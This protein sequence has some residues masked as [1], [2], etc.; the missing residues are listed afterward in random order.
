MFQVAPAHASAYPTQSAS[1]RPSHN[2]S[3][4]SSTALQLPRQL[5]RPALVDVPAANIAACAPELSGVPAEYIRRNL[6]KQSHEMLAGIQALSPAHL[7]K[8]LPKSRLPEML[9]VPIVQRTASLPTHILAVTSS[10]SAPSD[11]AM[12]FAVHGIVIA[13]HCAQMR[14]PQGYQQ[15]GSTARLPVV[16]ISPPSAHAFNILLDFMYTH[17]LDS[18]LRSLLPLPSSFCKDIT[19]EGVKSTTHSRS[20]IYQL[21]THLYNHEHGDVAA[22]MRHVG[23]CKDMWQDMIS[24]GM[25]TPELWDTLDLA[26]TIVLGAL[27]LVQGK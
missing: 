3:S 12:I 11:T 16:H 7:P 17:R 4:S 21:A 13:S 15:S 8:T 6:I 14:L 27:N 22:L 25:S 24:L 2:Y 5:D 10:R 26:W 19:H 20:T 18:V 23:H 9:N 1:R